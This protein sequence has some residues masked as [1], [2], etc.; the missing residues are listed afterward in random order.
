MADA[1]DW[2]NGYMDSAAWPAAQRNGQ[3]Y[4]NQNYYQPQQTK[5]NG[6]ANLPQQPASTAMFP[7]FEGYGYG[8]GM[9]NP[10]AMA[11]NNMAQYATGGG[12]ANGIQNAMMQMQLQ[13]LMN[14]RASID[15]RAIEAPIQQEQIRADTAR[16]LSS[17]RLGT[18]GPL[19]QALVGN[20]GSTAFGSPQTGFSAVGPDG[21]QFA[22]ATQGGSNAQPTNTAAFKPQT[23]VRSAPQTR[24]EPR[25]GGM[26]VRTGR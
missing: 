13:N 24:Y 11:F 16:S 3:N 19:L 5:W 1:P 4:W 20:L 14:Q 26:T 10:G 9:M 8:G 6:F 7:S 22:S 15:Q 25:F 2:V 21:K 23:A 12:F 18:I 17:D